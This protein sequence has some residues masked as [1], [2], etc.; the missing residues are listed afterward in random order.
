MSALSFIRRKF[1][2]RKEGILI[3]C[4]WSG[5][6]ADLTGEAVTVVS[7]KRSC[8]HVDDEITPTCQK[9]LTALHA[10]GGLSE[11]KAPCSKCGELGFG[12]IF[13]V[14]DLD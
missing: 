8:G 9:H 7:I 2:P 12:K 5:A 13:Q 1:G 11:S 3:R 14:D 6:H 4:Q 10:T